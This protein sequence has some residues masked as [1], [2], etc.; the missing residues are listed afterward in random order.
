M[1]LLA[2][3]PVAEPEI[4]LLPPDLRGMVTVLHGA[5]GPPVPHED[6]A[7]VYR[8]PSSGRLS[9]SSAPNWGVRS[10]RWFVED[11]GGRRE[12]P[13]CTASGPPDEVCIAGGWQVGAAWHF[14]VD[15]RANADRYRS[16]GETGE[17]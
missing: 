14:A 9:T 10:S 1:L 17:R 16:P 3:G 12:L 6:G 2:C 11:A 7:R 8:V 13:R 4:H 5:E 15:V